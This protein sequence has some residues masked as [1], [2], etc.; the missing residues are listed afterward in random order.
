M[1]KNDKITASE[2]ARYGAAVCTVGDQLYV[3]RGDTDVDDAVDLNVI[4]ALDLNN[5]KRWR[6]IHTDWDNSSQ[7]PLGKCSMAVC[8]IGDIIYTYGGWYSEELNYS[9]SNQLHG[10]Y[11]Q[12]M[13]W[14][15]IVAV[16]PEDGPGKK[17]KCG[18]VEHAGKICIFGGY[19]Y[20][21]DHQEKNKLFSREP[22]GF[23]CWTNEIHLYDPVIRKWSVPQCTGTPPAPCAAFSFNKIDQQRVLLFGGRQ[24]AGRVNEVHILNMDQWVCLLLASTA[25]GS[26]YVACG[27]KLSTVTNSMTMCTM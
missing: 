24:C 8:A 7:I 19:G 16:N 4:Y 12:E 1:E 17:D 13:I 5:C 11:L 25:V 10:L 18:M 21:T 2:L 26:T 27:F 20:L 15:E 9:R 6:K 14:K 22:F 23:L 3:W